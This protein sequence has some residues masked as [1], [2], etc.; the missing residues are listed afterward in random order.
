M[1]KRCEIIFEWL[2]ILLNQDIYLFTF[3]DLALADRVSGSGRAV[4]GHGV[5]TLTQT[6]LQTLEPGMPENAHIP[7]TNRFTRTR[8]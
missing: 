7:L 3:F 1:S 2:L 5:Y 6:E 4:D 8:R